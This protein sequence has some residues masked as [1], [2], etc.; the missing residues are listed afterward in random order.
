MGSVQSTQSSVWEALARH[1]GKHIIV[2]RMLD[3]NC[4]YIPDARNN[5]L[6]FGLCN[7][8]DDSNNPVG[9]QCLK[10][11]AEEPVDLQAFTQTPDMLTYA[12]RK[13]TFL[14]VGKRETGEIYYHLRTPTYDVSRPVH[15]NIRK[16]YKPIGGHTAQELDKLG[17][18][19]QM[20]SRE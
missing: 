2:E 10:I 9:N 18:L 20:G 5:Q 14:S 12:F 7:K 13:D 4:D 6:T 3:G 15:D 16:V 11:G 17:V 8:S 1:H 19:M